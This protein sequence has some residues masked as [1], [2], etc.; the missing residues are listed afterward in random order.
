VAKPRIG[1]LLARDLDSGAGVQDRPA[2]STLQLAAAKNESRRGT[3]SEIQAES[4]PRPAD[5]AVGRSEQRTGRRKRTQEKIAV[6]RKRTNMHREDPRAGRLGGT[7]NESR[8]HS[9]RGIT[10]HEQL[11]RQQKLKHENL[12]R[13]HVCAGTKEVA[14]DN[15]DQANW[16]SDTEI[17]EQLNE[18]PRVM[19]TGPTTGRTNRAENREHQR[20]NETENKTAER[21]EKSAENESGRLGTSDKNEPSPGRTLALSCHADENIRTQEGELLRSGKIKRGRAHS[22]YQ[23]KLIFLFKCEI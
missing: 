3:R 23:I 17:F 14:A 11:L 7:K 1:A 16:M 12:E 22:A 13:K 18:A 6:G 21:K 15:R 10:I 19:A 9:A 2:H 8:G 20:E 4:E 5:S